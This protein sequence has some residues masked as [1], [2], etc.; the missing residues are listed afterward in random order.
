MMTKPPQSRG[1]GGGG[2]LGR[3]GFAALLAA[4]VIA[5]ALLCL[6][7]GA[8]FAPTLRSRRL[9]LQRRF[10][11]VPADLALSSLPV[12]DLPPLP[13]PLF[14][15]TRVT[16]GFDSLTPRM[17]LVQVCDARYSELI[18]CL[19][20]GLHNQLRLRLNLSLMEHYERHCPP[21]HRRLNCLIPPPAGYRVRQHTSD[22]T[23]E[24]IHDMIDESITC[25]AVHCLL[26]IW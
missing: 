3:R 19:D 15:T 25:C 24:T 23:M 4:A 7:Y 8:A 10:E 2:A 1:G 18:P 11:A 12:R 13:P 14:R 20:R 21:A 26:F 9:P 22:P 5:L 6:F 16:D 17:G